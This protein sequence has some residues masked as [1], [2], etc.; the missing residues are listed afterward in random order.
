MDDESSGYDTP[1]ILLV[2]IDI[3]GML[4]HVAGALAHCARGLA[5][6]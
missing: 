4:I 5:H 6:V 2:M 1:V 3:S